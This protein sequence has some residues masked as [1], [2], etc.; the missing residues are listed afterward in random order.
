MQ[1][2]K[3]KLCNSKTFAMGK[4]QDLIVKTRSCS[5]RRKN[6][7]QKTFKRLE[8]ETGKNFISLNFQF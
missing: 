8:Q 3:N 7:I 2:S 5:W 6:N 1:I 4:V